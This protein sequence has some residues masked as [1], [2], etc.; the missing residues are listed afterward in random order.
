VR[1]SPGDPVEE[2]GDGLGPAV[3]AE[4]D[5]LSVHR[6]EVQVKPSGSSSPVSPSSPTPA[7]HPGTRLRQ[8]AR[9]YQAAITEFA[10]QAFIAA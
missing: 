10:Q 2:A 8:A 1:G 9:A 4:A 5:Q 7:R 6:A 3:G